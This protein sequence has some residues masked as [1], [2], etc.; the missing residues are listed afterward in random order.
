[1]LLQMTQ[2]LAHLHHNE[3]VHR[4]IKPNNIL[5]SVL[6]GSDKPEPQIKLAD[7]G[8]SKALKADRKD[9]TNTSVTNPSG[10]MGWMAP[11]LYECDRFDFK[12]DIFPLGCIF[13][14]TLTG[15]KHPFG[16]DLDKRISRIRDKEAMV[17]S[18]GDFTGSYSRDFDTE[19]FKLIESMLEMKPENRPTAAEVLS[20]SFFQVFIKPPKRQP[21]EFSVSN[22]THKINI[23]Q[24]KTSNTF[25]FFKYQ[26]DLTQEFMD[27][28]SSFKTSIIITNEQVARFKELVNEEKV[29]V[30]ALE[31]DQGIKPLF[32]LL[33]YFP[34]HPNLIELV[35]LLLLT[36][37]NANAKTLTSYYDHWTSLHALSKNDK[38]S[39][40]LKIDLVVKLAAWGDQVNIKDKHGK[41]PVHNFCRYCRNDNLIEIL[42]F[43]VPYSSDNL[44][45]AKDMQGD[46]PLHELCRHYNKDNLVDVAEFLIQQ[47]AEVDERNYK[48]ETPFYVLFFNQTENEKLIDVVRLFIECGG[49]N[50]KADC[51][52]QVGYTPLHALCENYKKEHLIM[53][54]VKLMEEEGADINATDYYNGKTPLSFLRSR[55]FIL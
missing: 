3:I 41:I 54:I 33:Y 8:I 13:A 16:F 7:F 4:D 18:P 36:D 19:A 43:L 44:T 35:E 11:E 25:V 27:I 20:S 55:G 51:T 21:I 28:C 2:G 38:L 34:D 23:Q 45:N 37:F 12:L 40:Q 26:M 47:G 53:D 50:V 17:F 15:G 14:Y 5:I 46:T 6:E 42:Q 30:D 22:I 52:K 1:M 24:G 10:T 29:N 32:L 49:V 48:M 9:Y 31:R 39:D